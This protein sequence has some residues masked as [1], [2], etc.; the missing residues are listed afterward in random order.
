MCGLK[1]W[2]LHLGT[3]CQAATADALRNPWLHSRLLTLPE[4]EGVQLESETH[5]P[6]GTEQTHK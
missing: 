3:V 1:K 5:W 2:L 4:K 6:S